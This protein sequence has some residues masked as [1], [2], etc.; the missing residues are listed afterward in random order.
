MTDYAAARLNMVESQLRPNKVMDLGVLHAFLNLPRESFVPDSLRGV[1]YVDEDVPLGRGR[2]LMEPMVLARLLQLASIK[3]ADTVLEIGSG[4][5][6]GTAVLSRLAD[7]VTGIEDDA[8]MARSAEATLRRLAITN[9]TVV[10]APLA[11]GHAALAPYDVIVFGGAVE[12]IPP[13]ALEQLAEGGRLVTVLTPPG[14]PGRAVLM[15]RIGDAFSRRVEFDASTPLL[16]G[17][18]VEPG[19]AF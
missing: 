10:A 11:D 17:L 16:P 8:D 13:R 3:P 18:Q 2:Y 5:G 7:T 9:A 14:E 1:A 15:T 6:Y 19:F 12:R 4:T